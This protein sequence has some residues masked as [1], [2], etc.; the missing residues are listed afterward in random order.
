M[1]FTAR[2]PYTA[3]KE[4]DGENELQPGRH[5]VRQ[6]TAQVRREGVH[7]ARGE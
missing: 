5:S 3:G 4:R 7:M 1:H 2:R 6:G